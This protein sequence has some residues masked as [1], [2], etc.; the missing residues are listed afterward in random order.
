LGLGLPAI[1]TLAAQA[2]SAD[3][4]TFGTEL[5]ATITR[6]RAEVERRMAEL[7]GLRTQ[8]EALQRHVVHCCDG[9]SP[10]EMAADCE[11][12]GLISATEGGEKR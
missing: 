7:Q 4:A 12:C 6:Q 2:F 9:C 10:Q 5:Q 1:R 3:C 8:L 11:F